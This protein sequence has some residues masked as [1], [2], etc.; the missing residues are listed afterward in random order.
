MSHHNMGAMVD[1]DAWYNILTQAS[2][3]HRRGQPGVAK[4][5]MAQAD[6]IYAE[7]PAFYNAYLLDVDGSLDLL[8]NTR[9]EI[10]GQRNPLAIAR[11]NARPNSVILGAASGFSE[12]LGDGIKNVKDGKWFF[13]TDP[14]AAV[15]SGLTWK[16]PLVWLGGGVVLWLVARNV[17]KIVS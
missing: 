7:D 6:G 14:A 8:K 11:A 9:L 1:G 5:L 17:R 12:G 2:Y 16:N 13:G 4:T 3:A 10:T 15:K